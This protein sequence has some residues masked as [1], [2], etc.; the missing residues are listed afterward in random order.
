M[1]LKVPEKLPS[2]SL[3]VS[4]FIVFPLLYSES[5]KT[6]QLQIQMV[7]RKLLNPA[8]YNP[9]SW[10]TKAKADLTESIKRFGIV[11]PII[12]NS[13]P[14]RR[15][16]IIGGHFRDAIAGELEYTEVPV[17]YINIP[18]EAKEKEL[19]L[20]L[21][22]NIGTWDFEKLK[23]FEIET[24]LDV[25]FDDTDL[26]HIWDETLGVEDDEFDVEKAIADIKEPTS[27]LG[28]IFRLG[29]HYLICGDATDPATIQQLIGKEQVSMI[30]SDPPYNISLNYNS[31]IGGK[32]TYGGK[33]NDQK[34]DEA[35]KLF[36]KQTIQ[37][38]LRVA[39]PDCHIFYYCDE[40]YIGLL[41]SLY[42]ELGINNK[43]VCLWIKNAQNPTPQI[44]FNKAYEPCV[45]GVRGNPYLAPTVTNL[46][47]I[48]NKETGTGNRLPDD[49]LDLFNIWLVKRLPGQDYEHPT[50]KPPSLHEKALRRCTKPGDIVLDLFGGSGSTLITCEQLKRK[51]FLCEIEPVFCDVIIKR[52]QELTG[53]EAVKINEYH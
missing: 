51:A 41:Q 46:N 13:A 35:Y 2:Y 8:P 30:Y 38:S 3:S 10:D 53:K 32:S 34:S 42:I 37:N 21:N 12:V 19:N 47:E 40:T 29:T 25:G 49:I 43:R 52:F 20:R 31:G 9:R 36:L 7:E 11:D 4:V 17:V 24:L 26:S 5:M 23:V 45:Y 15:N 27:K 18:D 33:T 48:L 28:D 6:N 44:A 14:N 1:K 39:K 16:I 22:R 50:Q